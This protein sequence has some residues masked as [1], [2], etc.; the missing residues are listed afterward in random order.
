M[1]S[2]SMLLF[3]GVAV[4]SAVSCGKAQDQATPAQGQTRQANSLQGATDWRERMQRGHN[5]D[6]S[7]EQ[8]VRRLTADLGLTPVQ[9]EKVRQLSRVHNDRIQ[10]ILDTAPP[11]LTYEDFQTQ[12]HAISQD[13]HDSVNAILTPR[14]LELM[15]AMVG[16]LDSGTEVRRAP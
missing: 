9:Q 6:S 4:L 7:T 11:T 14:Q 3:G 2:R 8:Q 16:R 12:V 1:R 13:F 5:A 15:K 10:K